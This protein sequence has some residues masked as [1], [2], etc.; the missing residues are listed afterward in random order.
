[1]QAECAAYHRTTFLQTPALFGAY[2]QEFLQQGLAISAHEYLQAQQTRARYRSE[3]AQLFEQADI[4]MTPATPTLAPY[5][6]ELT[7]SP[8]F[9]MPFTNAGVP[10]L[11]LP[12]GFPAR[13]CLSAC[14]GSPGTVMNRRWWIWGCTISR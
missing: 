6:L 4:L 5:S 1:M 14:S 2:L 9:N 7:G 8:A 11:A 13:D 10:T 3:L 12:V